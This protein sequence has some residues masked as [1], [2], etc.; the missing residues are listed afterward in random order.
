MIDKM[1]DVARKFIEAIPYARALGMRLD[2]IG[3]GVAVISMDYDSRY[4]GDPSTGVIHGGA[5]SIPIEPS[6]AAAVIPT[7]SGA[8]AQ[9]TLDLPAQLM[10]A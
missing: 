4:V 6:E 8:A 1:Q 9:A 2:E 7:P 5:V 10:T 3:A